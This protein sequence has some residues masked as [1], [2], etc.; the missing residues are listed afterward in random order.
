MEVRGVRKSCETEASNAVFSSLLCLSASVRLTS[1]RMRARSRVHATRPAMASIVFSCSVA[2]TSIITP[3]EVVPT[4]NGRYVIEEEDSVLS[5]TSADLDS[6]AVFSVTKRTD[7]NFPES[8]TCLILVNEG[9][10]M[11]S[12]SGSGAIERGH[13]LPSPANLKTAQY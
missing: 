9:V 4:C 6:S 5:L 2:E 11:L 7:F 8:E 12:S 13:H 1:A 3:I 10:I